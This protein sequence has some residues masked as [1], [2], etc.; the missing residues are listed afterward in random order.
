MCTIINN[1]AHAAL[2]TQTYTDIKSD[3]KQFEKHGIEKEKKNSTKTSG[4]ASEEEK[5]VAFLFSL[6]HGLHCTV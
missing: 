5:T 2:F 1:F 3:I 4:R 6:S